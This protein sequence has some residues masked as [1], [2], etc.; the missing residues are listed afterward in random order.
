MKSMKTP[1]DSIGNQILDV[2][3]YSTVPQ[4]LRHQ[5]CILKHQV[6]GNNVLLEHNMNLYNVLDNLHFHVYNSI[7]VCIAQKN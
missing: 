7:N 4:Q 2:S 3:A 5:Q 6:T 1:S